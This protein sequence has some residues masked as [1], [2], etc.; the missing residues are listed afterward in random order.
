MWCM[1]V[2][3]VSM[4]L[5]CI[6]EC[7]YVCMYVWMDV[8]ICIFCVFNICLYVIV[9]MCARTVWGWKGGDHKTCCVFMQTLHF[10]A[11]V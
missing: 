2:C 6:F 4:S 9:S 1:Y 11:N 8:Y 5:F 3:D 10:Y 7:M